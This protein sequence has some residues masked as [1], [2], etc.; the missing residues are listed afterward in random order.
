MKTWEDYKGHVRKID[1]E[2]GRD[3]DEAE[4]A[5][6]I[7]TAMVNR[8]NDLGLSQRDLAARCGI[9]QSS[10]ARIETYQTT[11]NLS[12]L[13]KI[14]KQLGLRTSVSPSQYKASDF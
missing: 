14:F 12:T 8:R 1:P 13:L 9:P 4:E 10:I 11:P 2:I 6:A 7:V 3:I 5:S